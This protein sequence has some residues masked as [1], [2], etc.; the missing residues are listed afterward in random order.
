LQAIEESMRLCRYED[1]S[2]KEARV[3]FYAEDR[4][5]PLDGALRASGA[6]DL[7]LA[8]DSVL[9]YLPHG[10]HAALAE[11]AWQWI[12]DHPDLP[13]PETGQVKLLLPQPR[14][15][16]LFLLAGNYA[17]HIEEGGGRAVE[18]EKTF[19]YVFMKPP[20]TTLTPAGAPVRIPRISP[21]H[22]DWELELG[23]LIGKG[24]KRIEEAEALSHVAGYTVINDISDRQFRPNPGRE[25]RPNNRY[26]DWLHGKWHDSFCACGPCATSAETLPDAG[27][28]PMRLSVNGETKQDVMMVQQ[29][30]PVEAVIAFISSFVTLE[31]GDL[32]ATGTP[33]GVGQASGTFLKP[34]DLM[35]AT[36]EEIGTLVSPVEAE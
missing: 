8:H 18:R 35:E 21:E 2:S 33:A 23:V 15:P 10:E 22:I 14:P 17:A 20:S 25:E 3:G 16:K 24:G 12:A 11:Q 29:I 34:G 28:L 4:I 19:P 36:I 32:I 1:P 30:F 27:H 9:P 26:F 5:V 7:P 6:G 31:P 13:G